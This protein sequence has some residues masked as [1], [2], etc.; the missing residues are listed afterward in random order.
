[1]LQKLMKKEDRAPEQVGVEVGLGGTNSITGGHQLPSGD[2]EG[3]DEGHSLDAAPRNIS[4]AAVN[5]AIFV[6]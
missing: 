3:V 4:E 2:G 5:F 1:M 6:F